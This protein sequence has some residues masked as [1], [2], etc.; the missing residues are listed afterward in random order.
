MPIPRSA[1]LREAMGAPF[2]SRSV[3]WTGPF[4][5]L[6]LMALLRR[7]STTCSMRSGSTW[8]TRC[9]SGV[10]KESVRWGAVRWKRA[11]TRLHRATRS[12]GSR[13]SSSRPACTRVASSSS[14]V[15]LTNPLQRFSLPVGETHLA[16]ELVLEQGLREAAQHGNGMADFVRDQADELVFERF[17]LFERCDILVDHDGCRLRC[18]SGIRRLMR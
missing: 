2:D 5:G 15:S 10:S 11:T 12:V 17:G 6:Y 18:F 9:S 1:T 7:L 8:A 4:S 13:A 16:T 14:S 3:T